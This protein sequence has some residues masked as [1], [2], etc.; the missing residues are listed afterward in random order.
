MLVLV[1]SSSVP[2]AVVTAPRLHDMQSGCTPGSVSLSRRQ[3]E[4]KYLAPGFRAGGT[5]R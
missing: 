3:L 2:H 4:S 5:I 1:P